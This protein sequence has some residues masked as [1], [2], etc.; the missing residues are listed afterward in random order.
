MLKGVS[1]EKAVADKQPTQEKDTE[2]PFRRTPRA[3]FSPPAPFNLLVPLVGTSP[4][5]FF[6]R[7]SIVVEPHAV[8]VSS[9]AGILP[10][11]QFDDQIGSS[12]PAGAQAATPAAA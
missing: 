4:V 11:R 1:P 3:G 9:D 2:Y 6:S 5:D 10:I 7:L 12:C 8:Q